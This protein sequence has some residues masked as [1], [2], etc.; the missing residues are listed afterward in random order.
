MLENMDD[1]M[2]MIPS[3]ML[4]KLLDDQRKLEA[5][6]AA[7]VDNWCG[8]ADAMEMLDEEEVEK[9]IPKKKSVEG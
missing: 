1:K 3:K 4:R 2:A 7:G 6:E 9:Y 8:Y 5:L